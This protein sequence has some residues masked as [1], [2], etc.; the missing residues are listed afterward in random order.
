MVS[1]KEL[2]QRFKIADTTVYRTLKACGLDTARVNYTEE[3][4]QLLFIP[5]RHLF[6]GGKTFKQVKAT[7]ALKSVTSID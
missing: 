5:A 2:E 3:E 4:I 6:Q 1:K 7:F